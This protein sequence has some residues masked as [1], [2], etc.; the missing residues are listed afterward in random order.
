MHHV[1]TLAWREPTPSE[2][3]QIYTWTT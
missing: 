1:L 2:T 3:T